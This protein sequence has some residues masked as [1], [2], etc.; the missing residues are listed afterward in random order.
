MFMVEGIEVTQVLGSPLVND[1][2]YIKKF[3][4]ENWLSR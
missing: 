3:V 4:D 1:M 2:I